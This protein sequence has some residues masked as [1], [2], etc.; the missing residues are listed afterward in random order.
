M[1]AAGAVLERLIRRQ[2]DGRRARPASS[3]LIF[4]FARLVSEGW[5]TLDELSS[6]GAEKV[7]FIEMLSGGEES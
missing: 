4:V 7:D 5:L 6:I 1:R 3:V 2:D